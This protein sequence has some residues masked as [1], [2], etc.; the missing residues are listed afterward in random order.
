MISRKQQDKI[1]S[2]QDFGFTG[3]MKRKNRKRKS[4]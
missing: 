2:L 3:T 1:Q 4:T